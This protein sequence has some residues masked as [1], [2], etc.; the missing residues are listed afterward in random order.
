MNQQQAHGQPKL[1][2]AREERRLACVVRSNRKATVAQIAKN[3]GSDK[4]VSEYTVHH[5]LL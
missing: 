1:T 5:S 4:K 2:D 3:A